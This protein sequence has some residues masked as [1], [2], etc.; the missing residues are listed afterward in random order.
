MT[1][2]EFQGSLNPDGTAK[3]PQEMAERL[4]DVASFRVLVLLP[5][6]DDADD[7]QDWQRLGLS[8]FFKDHD[9]SDAIMTIYDPGS[10]VL[11]SYPYSTG[12]R[13]KSRPVLVL[14]DSGD[15]DIVVAKIT[16]KPLRSK[17][18]IAIVDWSRA[19]LRA[20]SVVRLD[21]IHGRKKP[22]TCKFGL[23]VGDRSK[24]DCSGVGA[25]V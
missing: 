11:I 4:K 1:A 16:S 23:A 25:V 6:Y 2:L 24:I 9:D 20:S 10:I 13:A 18:D 15:A 21:K 19:G 12:T 17:N 14:I 7:D 5:D 3:V 8:Q 22:G